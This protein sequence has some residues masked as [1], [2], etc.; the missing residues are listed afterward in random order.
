MNFYTDNFR[1]YDLIGFWPTVAK[2]A[3]VRRREISHKRKI[4]NWDFV[5]GN[6]FHSKKKYDLTVK[7]YGKNTNTLYIFTSIY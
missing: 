6:P 4:V 5:P 2:Q 1:S 7:I 3:V